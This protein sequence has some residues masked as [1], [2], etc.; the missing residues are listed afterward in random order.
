MGRMPRND[1]QGLDGVLGNGSTSGS[2]LDPESVAI[3]ALVR[4][5][6]ADPTWTPSYGA[7]LDDVRDCV[8]AAASHRNI[9]RAM[10]AAVADQPDLAARAEMV[11]AQAR[12]V[13]ASRLP[14]AVETGARVG[15]AAQVLVRLK[16]RIRFERSA[17]R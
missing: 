11:A 1:G 12:A 4:W 10:M 15:V 8:N 14:K 3:A 9:L 2:R 5:R 13:L 7:L 6:L 17:R 16:S